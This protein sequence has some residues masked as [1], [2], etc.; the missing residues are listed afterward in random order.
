MDI[1]DNEGVWIVPGMRVFPEME[2]F[3]QKEEKSG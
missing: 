3:S 2:L 1:S